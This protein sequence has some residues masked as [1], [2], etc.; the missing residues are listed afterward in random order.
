VSDHD[1][2]SYKTTGKF[3]VLYFSTSVLLDNKM[4]DNR[5]CAEWWKSFP[6]FKLFLISSWMEFWLDRFDP[7]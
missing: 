1:S 3:I 4:D 5:F 2:H 6:D 7:N